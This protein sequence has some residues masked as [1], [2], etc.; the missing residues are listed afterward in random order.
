[1][2]DYLAQ[3]PDVFVPADKDRRFFGGDLTMVSRLTEAEFLAR[4]AAAAGERR[5]LDASVYYLLSRTAAT[6]IR[7]FSPD[8][9]IVAMFRNPVD[10]LYAHHAQLRFNG[11]GEDEDLEDFSEALAAEPDR[12][13]GQRLPPGTRVREALYYRELASYAPQLQRYFDVFGRE[14]VHVIVFDDFRADPLAASQGLMRFLEV[15]DSFAPDTR[16]VNPNTVTRFPWLRSAL[17]AVPA[18]AKRALPGVVRKQLS[19]RLRSANTKVARRPPLDPT[20]RARLA[21]ELRP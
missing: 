13:A 3:H 18:D 16:V 20:L 4:Y 17:A 6:E 15:D 1:M 19:R 8:A 7:A 2:N 5:A 11:L 9:R 21:A 10:M 12:R 14:R